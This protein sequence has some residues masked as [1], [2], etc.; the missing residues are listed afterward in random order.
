MGNRGIR[1]GCEEIDREKEK[2]GGERYGKK[3]VK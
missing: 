3:A 2:Q 1:E